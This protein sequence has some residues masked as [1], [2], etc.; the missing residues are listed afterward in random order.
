[1]LVFPLFGLAATLGEN[2]ALDA[3]FTVVSLVRSYTL[4][5]MFEAHLRVALTLLARGASVPSRPG[6]ADRP[7]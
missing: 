2:L 5:R 4:S 1:M 7:Q 6:V 3:I